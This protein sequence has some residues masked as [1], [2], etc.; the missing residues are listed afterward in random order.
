M[1]NLN[2]AI[3]KNVIVIIV[4]AQKIHS[5]ALICNNENFPELSAVISLCESIIKCCFEILLKISNDLEYKTLF[6]KIKIQT[7]FF[8]N[9]LKHCLNNTENI[10]KTQIKFLK[11]H[12]ETIIKINKKS[13]KLIISTYHGKEIKKIK[14]YKNPIEFAKREIEETDSILIRFFS[15]VRNY[16]DQ[17]LII[18]INYFEEDKIDYNKGCDL[19]ETFYNQ[20]LLLKKLVDCFIAMHDFIHDENSRK[21]YEI[22]VEPLMKQCEEFHTCLSIGTGDVAEERKNSWM[23]MKD[24]ANGISNFGGSSEVISRNYAQ[25]F[26][27][28]S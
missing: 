3:K 2:I 9:I 28:F 21:Q 16:E 24:L 26:D 22:K 15:S 20:R 8:E 27:N 14:K 19:I 6:D 4:K 23:I 25:L 11:D 12:L 13:L 18:F 7:K 1:G 17:T 5:F 10:N